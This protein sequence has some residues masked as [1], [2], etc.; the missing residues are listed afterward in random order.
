MREFW[1]EFNLFSVYTE[2]GLQK[3]P[4]IYYPLYDSVSCLLALRQRLNLPL[5][6]PKP[7]QDAKEQIGKGDKRGVSNC[8]QETKRDK[9]HPRETAKW[10]ILG[11]KVCLICLTNV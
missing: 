7:P 11:Q 9:N 4:P 8:L 5:Q 2:K 3:Y 1:G 6:A 10:A